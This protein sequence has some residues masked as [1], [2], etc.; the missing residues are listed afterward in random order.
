MRFK[1]FIIGL[2]LF[3]ALQAQNNYMSLAFAGSWPLHEYSQHQDLFC[4][5]FALRGF[6]GDY[7]GA[8]FNRKNL[9]IG[10]SIRYTSNPVR[11]ESILSLLANE[12]PND[13]QF[14]EDPVYTVGFWKLVSVLS[15]PEY[16][17][18]RNNM[19]LD[20][21][22][23]AGINFILAPEMD[24]YA[25]NTEGYFRRELDINTLN[26]GLASGGALRYHLNENTS[27][28]IYADWFI[29]SCRGEVT[30]TREFLDNKTETTSAYHFTI[31]IFS[32]GI[33]VVYRL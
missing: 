9:G 6:A 2:S 32:A 26:A 14:S 28:R 20:L 24:I 19:N 15:G 10:G 29:S 5:G 13:L 16:T 21:Y 18:P 22:I 33:G 27:V 3:G 7:S 8:F 30:Q 1:I 31:A 25:Q 4:D 23:R 17:F 11:D 12:I